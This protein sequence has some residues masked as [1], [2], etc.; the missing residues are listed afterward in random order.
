[1]IDLDTF[2]TYRLDKELFEKLGLKEYKQIKN[3]ETIEVGVVET[4]CYSIKISVQGCPVQF[5]TAEI[6]PK[7]EAKTI[8]V[9]TGSGCLSKYWESIEGI[10][11]GMLVV[12]VIED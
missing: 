10:A 7:G 6:T 3:W 1:M 4:D 2:S 8:K 12:T 9:E 11:E 5:F